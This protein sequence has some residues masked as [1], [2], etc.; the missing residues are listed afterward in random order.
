MFLQ[1]NASSR[2]GVRVEKSH[3][4]CEEKEGKQKMEDDS[5]CCP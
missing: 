2:M 3:V 4:A 1:W 5:W